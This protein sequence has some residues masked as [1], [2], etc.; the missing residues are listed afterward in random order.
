MKVVEEDFEES[1]DSDFSMEIQLTST[2]MLV[3]TFAVYLLAWPHLLLSIL[4]LSPTLRS[5]PFT[6]SNMFKEKEH[7]PHSSSS[8]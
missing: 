5:P 1:E 2:C 8:I 4:Y 6:I 3:I 7:F